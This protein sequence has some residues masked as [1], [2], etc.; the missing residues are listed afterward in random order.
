MC[1]IF[2]DIIDTGITSSE[3]FDSD[4][5]TWPASTDSMTGQGDKHN[6]N[7]GYHEPVLLVPHGLLTPVPGHYT[8][9][10]VSPIQTNKDLMGT[11]E[12]MTNNVK[13]A[14]RVNHLE[15]IP[16]NN[17]DKTLNDQTPHHQWKSEQFRKKMDIQ[18]HENTSKYTKPDKKVYSK[19]N[20]FRKPIQTENKNLGSGIRIYSYPERMKNPD[21]PLTRSRNFFYNKHVYEKGRNMPGAIKISDHRQTTPRHY[22]PELVKHGYYEHRPTENRD[23]MRSD[24]H[25]GDRAP[26]L[27][28]SDGVQISRPLYLLV[29]EYDDKPQQLSSMSSTICTFL[30]DS[31]YPDVSRHCVYYFVCH[32]GQV[33]REERCSQGEDNVKYI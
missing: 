27:H 25:F 6:W 1:V 28:R 26:S 18:K 5:K 31:T 20:Q 19:L 17:F 8:V 16:K 30:P 9:P 3:V 13:M 32:Q 15:R 23:R 14:Y 10:K 11:E 24:F 29:A 7:V 4:E 21:G 2:S 12:Q 22:L 33:L